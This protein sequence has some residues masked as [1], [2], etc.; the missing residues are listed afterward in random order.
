MIIYFGLEFG[1]Q[2]IRRKE[3]EAFSEQDVLYLNEQSILEQLEVYLGMDGYPNNN[4]FLRIEQTRQ[5]LINYLENAKVKAFF[6]DSFLVDQLATAATILSFR[7]ELLLSGW[8]FTVDNHTTSRLKALAEIHHILNTTLSP[9][10]ADRFTLVL[11]NIQKLDRK[12]DSIYL[13]EPRA[14]LP[15]HLQRLFEVLEKYVR[16]QQIEKPVMSKGNNLAFFQENLLKKDGKRKK[17]KPRRDD[18]S[19]LIIRAKRETEAATQLAQLLRENEQYRPVCIIPEKNRALDSALYHE[20]LPSMGIL[21][22]SLGRP[23]LQILKL[24]TTFLWQPIDPFK[25]LEFVSL[26]IKP[27]ADDLSKIIAAEM[28][29]TP[30]LKGD[31]WNISIAQYFEEIE[32]KAKTDLSINIDEIREQYNFWFNRKR[33]DVDKTA[34]KEEVLDIFKYIYK[35]SFKTIEERGAQNRSLLVLREQAKRMIELLE[36]I[37]KKET[38]LNYLEVERIVRTIYE[39][40]PV[41]FVETQVGHLP[42]VYNLSAIIKDV[43]DILWWNFTQNETEQFFSRWYKAELAYL[44]TKNVKLNLPEQRNNLRLWQRKQAVLRA[45]H[46]LLLVIPD[47]IDG[48]EVETHPLFGNIAAIFSDLEV[49]CFDLNDQRQRSELA[50]KFNLLKHTKIT[51]IE[52]GKPQTFINIKKAEL[53]K[54]RDKESFTSLD[55]F[56]Y[57]PYKW[58]FKHKIRLNSS[59]ILSV[60]K[61]TTLFGNL[62]HRFFEEIFKKEDI[63]KWTKSSVEQWIN[64]NAHLMLAKEGAVLLMYGREPEKVSFINKMKISVW[65]LIKNI[66]DN[67]WT[68]MATE[69]AL[70]G[71]FMGIPIK[72]K[73]DLVLERGRELAVV[74]LKWRGASRRIQQISNEEDLQLVMYS[75]LLTDD[76]DWTHTSYFIIETGEMIA[77]N[78]LAFKNDVKAVMPDSDHRE[79]NARI[80]QRMEATFNWRMQQIKAGKI[81]V[82]TELTQAELEEIYMDEL[83]DVLEMKDKD[84]PFDDFKTLINLI[85]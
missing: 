65:R 54:E 56:F 69:M 43:P 40:A 83:L 5:V 1:E 48:E 41:Q 17:I 24:V 20:G 75:R 77:R 19:L 12:I 44:S 61:D 31:S 4:E 10:Y 71:K 64:D 59:S 50:K 38:E 45:T 18:N 29:K 37:P 51:P 47:K 25:I 14:F 15:I 52:L 21:S 85:K 53:F 73:A 36:A 33:Y 80:W 9:G 32:N 6:S 63:S 42:F 30:G 66:Q 8:D 13:N 67:G 22:A 27:L 72:G 76:E 49:I 79:I 35:W 39:P 26:P 55:D 82:R 57:Y 7:D 16:L 81:E 23:T 74:D 70:K 46:S 34:P 84:A 58:V 60:V 3:V 11:R 62:A 2:V 28:S 78:N 68:I